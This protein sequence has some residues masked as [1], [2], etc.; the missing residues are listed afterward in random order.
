MK[1]MNSVRLWIGALAAVLLLAACGAA[2][3]GVISS[4]STSSH[5]N[6]V[7]TNAG[8]HNAAGSAT[9][10]QAPAETPPVQQGEPP[11]P[12]PVPNF[13]NVKSGGP[14]PEPGGCGP[15][16]PQRPSPKLLCASP[17]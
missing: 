6:L 17:E 14:L 10:N 2:A 16:F 5:P 11:A 4:K 15:V 8:T 9:E 3:A 12:A 7:T 13:P 1:V